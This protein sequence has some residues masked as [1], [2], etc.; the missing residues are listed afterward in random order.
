M[1]PTGD[2][3]PQL[4][5]AAGSAFR[6]GQA[7]RIKKTIQEGPSEESPGGTFAWEGEKVIVRSV[8]E[9]PQK[10]PITVSHEGRKRGEG[11][12]VSPDEI[13]PW[14]ESPNSVL[15]DR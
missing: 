14:M 12:G 13:E 3:G 10:W 9:K 8:S 7:V 6:E 5:G 1:K 4:A 15:N 11:F 2:S